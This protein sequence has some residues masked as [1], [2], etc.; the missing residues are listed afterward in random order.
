MIWILGL[1][2]L[3]LQMQV[4]KEVELLADLFSFFCLVNP[5][6][7]AG[8]CFRVLGSAQIGS[9]AAIRTGWFGVRATDMLVSDWLSRQVAALVGIKPVWEV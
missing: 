4:Q 6:A 7:C 1:L 9:N 2:L 3:K 8:D 5:L